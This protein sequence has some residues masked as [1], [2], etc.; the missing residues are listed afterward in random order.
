MDWYVA[1]MRAEVKFVLLPGLTLGPAQY[2]NVFGRL[3][4]YTSLALQLHESGKCEKCK[5]L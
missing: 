2:I 4:G 1:V 3:V 5:K